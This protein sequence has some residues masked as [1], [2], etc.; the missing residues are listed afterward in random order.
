VREMN[1]LLRRWRW[2]SLSTAEG[3]G[4]G[5]DGNEPR[6]GLAIIGLDFRLLLGSR[7]TCIFLQL[8]FSN[9]SIVRKIFFL[10]QHLSLYPNI[11]WNIP[12]ENLIDLFQWEIEEIISLKYSTPAFLTEHRNRRNNLIDLFIF[13]TQSHWIFKNYTSLDLLIQ[14]KL[15]FFF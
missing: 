8:G 6:K 15:L 7:L 12:I 10:P 9:I 11:F 1:T 5:D 14:T 4:L 13:L 2:L 3:K